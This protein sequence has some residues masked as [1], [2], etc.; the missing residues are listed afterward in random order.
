MEPSW[1]LGCCGCDGDLLENCMYI[2]IYIN[3]SICSYRYALIYI[4][5]YW[6]QITST[7]ILYIQYIQLHIYIIIYI[8]IYIAI[9]VFRYRYSYYGLSLQEKQISGMLGAEVLQYSSLTWR[10]KK[11]TSK[12][13]LFPWCFFLK[14]IN[15]WVNYNTS[16]T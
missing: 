8:I 6:T 11:K 2:Y 7:C 4:I 10:Q 13:V 14:P 15:I 3:L 5:Y 16:L 9:I 1:S 12:N